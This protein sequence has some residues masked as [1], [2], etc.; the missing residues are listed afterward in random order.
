MSERIPDTPEDFTKALLE[1][2]PKNK[3]DWKYIQL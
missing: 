3:G 2:P 1:T